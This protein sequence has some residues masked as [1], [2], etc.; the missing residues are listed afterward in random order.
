MPS[1]P[2]SD[3]FQNPVQSSGLNSKICNPTNQLLDCSVSAPASVCSSESSLA[4]PV[5]PRAIKSFESS[6]ECEITPEKEHPLLLQHLSSNASLANNDPSPQ[7]GEVT[8]CNPACLSQKTLKETFTADSLKECNA[9][10]DNCGQERPVEVTKENS[11]AD[12]A[13]KH[14]QSKDV[15]LSAECELPIDRQMGHEPEKEHL[16]K[17]TETT[18]PEPPRHVGGIEKPVGEEA[19]WPENPPMETRGDGQEKAGLVCAK[20]SLQMSA[21]CSCT[22]KECFMEIDV[23]EQCVAEAHG[24]AGEQEQQAESR[25]VSH[26]NLDTFSMEVES[27]KSASSPSDLL[28]T[29]DVL[30]CKG[31]SE[32]AVKC[33]EVSNLAAEGSSSRSS[34]HQLDTDPGRSSEEPCFSLASAL[35]ELHKLLVISR[36]GEW[37]ILASEE[38]SQ[39]ET[40]HREPVAQQKGLSENEQ[41]GSDPARQEQSCSFSKVRSE[42]ARVEGKPLGDL[43]TE[44]VGT[45]SVSDV[46]SAL[47]E[48]AFSIQKL[49]GKSDSVVVNSAAT[50]DQ[51][52]SSEQVEVLAEGNRCPT[53]PASEQNTPVSST[54]ALDEGAPR[55]PQS[56]VTGAPGRS[57]SPAPEGPWPLGGCEEPQLSPP[58]GCTGLRSGASP[59]PAFPAA[60]VDRIL[61]AGFTTQEA[62]EALEQADGNAD[63]ALLILL[64]KSIVVPT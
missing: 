59:P 44:H 21:S 63:L 15:C 16:E 27:L 30:Q 23:A 43:G 49:S 46:Q 25:R 6:T 18:E 2:A 37:K 29:G 1:L 17:Q 62:L 64:A 12:T 34:L 11:L 22:R 40:V 54:S 39:L 42:G 26:L 13:D 36:K 47:G 61:G 28:S 24:S 56:L 8:C 48:G 33:N 51:Q 19:S 10:E 41:K 4:E 32:I 55:D 3:G 35:K 9:K 57:S 20:G 31:T 58:A 53:S 45:G 5:G 52:H 14:E 38:V 7:T 50:P 60:D